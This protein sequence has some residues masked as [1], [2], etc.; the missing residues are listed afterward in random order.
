LASGE[1]GHEPSALP[2]SVVERVLADDP[3]RALA[4]L[5]SI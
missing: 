4:Q 5:L 2:A 1:L 3:E